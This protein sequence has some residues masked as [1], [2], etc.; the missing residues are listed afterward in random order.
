MHTTLQTKPRAFKTRC[1]QA[2][3]HGLW[4]A[5][6]CALAPSAWAQSAGRVLLAVGDTAVLRADG[7]VPLRVGDEVRAGDVLV[8][9]PGAALQVRLADAS[10]LAV[11]SGSRLRVQDFR[12]EGKAESDRSVLQ[13]L[14]GGLR[15]ITGLIGKQNP[16]NV[17]MVTPTSTIGIRGTHFAVL[18]CADDCVDPAV[19][20]AV[21]NGTYGGVTDGR[22]GV[23]NRG[24]DITFAQQEFFY[25]RD[26]DTPAERL[27]GP[28]AFLAD[29]SALPP[30]RPGQPRTNP[31]AGLAADRIG[32]AKATAIT[33]QPPE[34]GT[35]ATE[36]AGGVVVDNDDDLVTG[37]A[38]GGPGA[39][40][41][42]VSTGSLAYAVMSQTI[43]NDPAVNA[44]VQ[45][46]ATVRATSTGDGA[47]DAVFAN[48]AWDS[49]STFNAVAGGGITRGGNAAAGVYWFYRNITSPSTDPTSYHY[50]FG[51]APTVVL[52]NSGL[53]TYSFLGA[54]TP[55][56]NLSRA[57]TFS[58]A[59]LSMNFGTQTVT[60]L[61]AMSVAFSAGG[62]YGAVSYTLPAGTSYNLSGSS[63]LTPTCTGCSGAPAPS[64][65]WST[66][67]QFTGELANGYAA[68]IGI[69]A[70]VPGIT[71]GTVDHA[72]GVAAGWAR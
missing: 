5:L 48:T 69:A 9:G 32:L 16:N 25:V 20:S 3:C 14:S 56:D 31:L 18:H 24:G 22:I 64:P 60:T 71:A 45:D 53:A 49:A 29:R 11:R 67:G 63:V 42:A 10:M 58:G 40:P 65:T 68:T 13:L 26:A 43:P 72:A 46:F 37:L 52:P 28:P 54:T 35:L 15:T 55:T 47:L 34:L 2:L 7:R 8:T 61:G 70:Q 4:L 36:V 33:P 21:A 6:L 59:A 66:A 39:A 44:G 50:A 23:V 30:P 12:F 27:I 19:G 57:G 17:Q 51:T 38:A 62:G 41:G 1:L